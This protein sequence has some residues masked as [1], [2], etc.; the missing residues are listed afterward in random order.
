VEFQKDS[1]E[2]MEINGMNAFVGGSTSIFITVLRDKEKYGLCD[3]RNTRFSIYSTTP[4]PRKQPE[5]LRNEEIRS[6]TKSKWNF[7]TKTSDW[8]QKRRQ[9]NL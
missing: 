7:S 6:W 4:F 5:Q 2:G 9:V 3:I 8:N 1:F